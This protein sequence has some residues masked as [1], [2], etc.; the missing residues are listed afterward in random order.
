MLTSI[1][2]YSPALTGMR[3]MLEASVARR[4]DQDWLRADADITLAGR[5]V[6]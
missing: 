6:R 3:A 4:C 2:T 1:E 5:S